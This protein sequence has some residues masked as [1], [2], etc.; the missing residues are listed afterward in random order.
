MNLAI[1]AAFGLGG[2]ESYPAVF[3]P[4]GG[5][6][7]ETPVRDGRIR[8]SDAPGIGVEAKAALWA[9]ARQ[10]VGGDAAS[11]QATDRR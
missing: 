6:A 5:F 1:A 2:V 4:F 3:A 11:R 9:L 8:P 10:V 7:D